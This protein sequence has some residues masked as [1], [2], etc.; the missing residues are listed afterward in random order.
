M[1]DEAPAT[2]ISSSVSRG[3]G[4]D[5]TNGNLRV[6]VDPTTGCLTATRVSDGVVLLKQTSL[7]FGTPDVPVTR[8]NSALVTAT[9]AG[10]AGERV[11]VHLPLIVVHALTVTRV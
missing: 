5:L 7:V 10:T 11:Y 3:S 9:F 4:N 2:P 1:G 6:V 8:P